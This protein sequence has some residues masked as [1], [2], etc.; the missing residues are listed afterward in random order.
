MSRLRKT[1]CTA[2]ITCTTGIAFNGGSESRLLMPVGRAPDVARG[3]S[4]LKDG[5]PACTLPL[6]LCLGH[7]LPVHPVLPNRLSREAETGGRGGNYFPR[8]PFLPFLLL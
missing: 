6:A 3:P 1:R 2:C 8:M 5:I 4:A 7:N